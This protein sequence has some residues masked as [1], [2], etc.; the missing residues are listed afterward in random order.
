MS[1]AIRRE[2]SSYLEPAL[3]DACA[4]Q[5]KRVGVRTRS[6]YVRRA[7]ILALRAEGQLPPSLRS[8]LTS[9]RRDYRPKHDNGLTSLH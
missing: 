7:V 5:A 8:Q 1:D 6:R 9:G 3:A 2:Y 4:Q